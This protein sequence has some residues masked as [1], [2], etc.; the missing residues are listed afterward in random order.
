[1]IVQDGV[2]PLP[3]PP[4]SNKPPLLPL[5]EPEE[6]EVSVLSKDTI[7]DFVE[8]EFAVVEFYAPTW[9]HCRMLFPE[10]TKASIELRALDPSIR[11]V[12]NGWYIFFFSRFAKRSFL[13]YL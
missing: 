3:L 1:M 2:T 8:A 11:S 6:S 12:S 9:P 10:Y 5:K 13:N 4:V 7:F